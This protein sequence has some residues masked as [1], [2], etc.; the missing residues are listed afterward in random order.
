MLCGNNDVNFVGFQF[1]FDAVDFIFFAIQS[2]DKI[3]ARCKF[4]IDDADSW[5]KCKRVRHRFRTNNGDIF[6]EF[7][8][9]KIK[10]ERAAEGIAINGR[11][12]HQQNV[13][14]AQ[15]GLNDLLVDFFHGA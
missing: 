2:Y 7:F 10:C 12:R 8:E 5:Q 11:G 1:G 9:S 15:N 3:V 6:F 4:V 13:V 14:A